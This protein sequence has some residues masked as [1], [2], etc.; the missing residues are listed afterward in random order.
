[1]PSLISKLPEGASQPRVRAVVSQLSDIIKKTKG[2]AAWVTFGGYSALDAANVSNISTTFIV[3]DDWSKRGA[4]LSQDNILANLR[5]EVAKV[6]DAV[7]FVIVPP[8]IRGLG[9]S[10]GFQMMVEDRRSLG[11]ERT[12]E[13]RHGSHPGRGL[14]VRF[15]QLEHDF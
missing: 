4:A 11:L 12:P 7:I 2:I 6:A 8:P 3:Y 15:A 9:Q 14:P 10:G 1:M 5:A 13:N